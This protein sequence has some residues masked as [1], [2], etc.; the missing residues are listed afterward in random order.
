MTNQNNSA[1][2]EKGS[3]T[4]R[5]IL[6]QPQMWRETY[7]KL[8][9]KIEEFKQFLAKHGIG[10]DSDVIFCGAGS[11]EFVADA[12]A[13]LYIADGFSKA[14]S[15]ATTDI[16]TDPE[17]YVHKDDTVVAFSFARSGNSPESAGAY[18]MLNH[19]CKKAYHIII[20]CNGKG[21][22][23]RDMNPDRDFCFVLPD[24]TDDVSLVMTSS[25]SSMAMAATMLRDPSKLASQKDA[26]YEA[27]SFA[28][29][30]FTPE[31]TEAVARIAKRNVK[32]AVVLGGGPLKGIAR[33]CHLK[34]QEMTDGA[35]MSAYDSFMG[36]RHGPKAVIKDDTVVVYL[37][38]DDDYSRQYE[39]DLMRQ[40]NAEHNPIAQIAVSKKPVDDPKVKLD[41][42]VNCPSCSPFS[43]NPY[44]YVAYVIIGQILG[45]HF[46]LEHGLNPDSPS[47]SGVIS[48]VVNGVKIYKQTK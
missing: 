26:V 47:V 12:V 30:F 10:K 25:F 31:V 4:K 15:V 9:A 1:Q 23:L 37:L 20:T 32:R 7:D 34:M 41:L 46:S 39:L 44:T 17:F 35:I 19:F 42:Q 5:E 21:D 16:V 38:S 27:A 2:P 33:E 8:A 28:E 43:K 45:Y 48:R 18:E 14:R 3:N 13:C 40:I 29:C 36:L 22:M 11:S 6:Q 24:P